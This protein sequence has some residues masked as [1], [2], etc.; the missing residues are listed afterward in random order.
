MSRIRAKDT[1]PETLVRS[2]LHKLGFRFR[3]HRKDLPGKPDIVLPK[4]KT[5][6]EVR[7]CYWHRHLGCKDATLPKTNTEFWRK[8]FAETVNR[9]IKN[10]ELLKNLGW[11]TLIVWE[12]ETINID[13]LAETLTR[14]FEKTNHDQAGEESAGF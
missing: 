13:Q 4:Y 1:K 11:E 14:R 9:D 3:L 8:K 2:L 6:I 5:V 10:V 7:G 12:C